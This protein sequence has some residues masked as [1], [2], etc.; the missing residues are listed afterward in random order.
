M[1]RP[2]PR[3]MK[4]QATKPTFSAQTEDYI[5]GMIFNIHGHPGSGKTFAALQASESWPKDLAAHKA[6]G[7]IAHLDDLVYV[8]WDRQGAVGIMPHGIRL[9]YRVSMTDLAFEKGDLVDAMAKMSKDLYALVQEDQNIKY[10][11]H[12]TVTRMDSMIETYCFDPKRATLDRNG[13]VDG[14]R[15]Y[16]KVAT[17]HHEYQ[18]SA[19]TL[20]DRIS[21]IFLFHQKVMDE[22]VGEKDAKRRK[23]LILK[24]GDQTT[25]VV[26]AI[27]GKS[28]NV[29]LADSSIEFVCKAIAKK[30]EDPRRWLYAATI[31]GERAKN[32]LQGVFDE[33]EPADMGHIIA[34]ARAAC[35]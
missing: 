31:D 24:M 34:K 27:T 2:T 30:G 21:N 3:G 9:K 17:I 26:P 29:Y 5:S 25:R 32:R 10:V 7:K 13:E 20:P 4:P 1:A 11:V 15:T 28:A 33:K 6:T 19:V 8:E 18:R 35:L 16:G 22:R 12:D 14:Q 23:D